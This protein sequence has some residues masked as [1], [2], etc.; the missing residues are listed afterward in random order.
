MMTLYLLLNIFFVSNV[1]NNEILKYTFDSIT[2]YFSMDVLNILTLI[3]NNLSILLFSN[4]VSYHC[5]TMPPIPN[6]LSIDDIAKLSRVEAASCEESSSTTEAWLSTENWD[7]GWDPESRRQETGRVKS[8]G[9]YQS[10]YNKSRLNP[11][12]I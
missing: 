6:N 3:K 7:W 4:F 9:N 8:E 10:Q 11:V 2:D 1:F 5:A 12:S